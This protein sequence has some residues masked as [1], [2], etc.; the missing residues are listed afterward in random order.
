MLHVKAESFDFPLIFLENLQNK[1]GFTSLDFYH[2]IWKATWCL[3]KVLHIQK[4]NFRQIK[5]FF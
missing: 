3:S 4:H 1:T 2:M 5:N